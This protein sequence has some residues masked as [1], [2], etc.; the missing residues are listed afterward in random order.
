M[1]TKWSEISHN[2]TIHHTYTGTYCALCG[3]EEKDPIHILKKE[4]IK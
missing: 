2:Y 4:N 1:E 3:K